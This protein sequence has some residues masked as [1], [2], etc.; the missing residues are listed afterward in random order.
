MD[1]RPP[2][3]RGE[4]RLRLLYRLPLSGREETILAIGGI[5][6][7]RAA[8]DRDALR[9]SI[10][11]VGADAPAAS[12]R[13]DAV[14]LPGSLTGAGEGGPPG[15]RSIGPAALLGRAH[16]ALRPGGIVVGH[17]DHLASAHGVRQVLQGQISPG[18][19]LRCRAV[20]SGAQCHRALVDAGFDE[21]ECFYVE[22]RIESP[23]VLV[24]V[25][26][27]AARSHFL[28]AI[29]RTRGQYST[30]GFLL[31][32]ALARIRLGG[33]LQPHLFFWARRPC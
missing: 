26:A 13:Y 31:R 29:R 17:L 20:A 24:P 5:D 6:Q 32:M 2:Y 19:W 12:S 14:V 9:A 16:T 30:P 27:L 18:A 10:D 33:I 3:A 4:A 22:P 1:T 23:M 15:R 21:P 11:V 8:L 7:A 25:H 28:R